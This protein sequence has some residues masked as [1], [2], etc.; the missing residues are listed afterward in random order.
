MVTFITKHEEIYNF[1]IE[2]GKLVSN[3]ES[4]KILFDESTG[5]I[6]LLYQF[7]YI[8]AETNETVYVPAYVKINLMYF[9]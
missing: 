1:K 3:D 4:I 8:D 9:N 6:S 7:S 2:D 5:I